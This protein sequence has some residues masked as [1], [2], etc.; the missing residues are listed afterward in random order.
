MDPSISVSKSAGVVEIRL[1]ARA[2]DDRTLR[3][4][5]IRPQKRRAL[6]ARFEDPA[7]GAQRENSR[8]P[9]FGEQTSIVRRVLVEQTQSRRAVA[10][11]E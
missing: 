3:R 9:P 10:S 11:A 8:G 5:R 1:G 2:F 4:I 6:G 7:D